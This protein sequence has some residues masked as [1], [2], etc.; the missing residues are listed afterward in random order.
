M[1]RTLFIILFLG[2]SLHSCRKDIS[3]DDLVQNTEGISV[4]NID[5][6]SVTGMQRIPGI[7]YTVIYSGSE[8]FTFSKVGS[9]LVDEYGH[10]ISSNLYGGSFNDNVFGFTTDSDGN[11][12]V[13][14]NTFSPELRLNIVP[15]PFNPTGDAYLCKLDKNGKLVWQIGYSDTTT[16]NFGSLAE[17]FSKV[18]VIGDSI[19]C[20]G[21]TE[22]YKNLG[23]PNPNDLLGDN[24]LVAFNKN[25]Q[26]GSQRILPNLQ[27]SRAF[28]PYGASNDMIKCANN[29]LI[30]INNV[31]RTFG[32]VPESYDTSCVIT[33]YSPS[34]RSVLWT[35]YGNR[36]ALEGDIN[37]MVELANGDLFCLNSFKTKSVRLSGSSG[38][39]LSSSDLN[40][41]EDIP[42]GSFVTGSLKIVG[43]HLYLVGSV[44]GNIG[45]SLGIGLTSGSNR[46]GSKPW[47]VK[48]DLEGNVIYAQLYDVEEAGF[49]DILQKED[50]NLQLLG[51]VSK[52]GTLSYSGFFLTLD[53]KGDIVTN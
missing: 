27:K 18:S 45:F 13:C 5:A 15:S 28:G 46:K 40:I 9:A 20:Y 47:L 50:G 23:Q 6:R 19:Y 35:A 22:N 3:E 25:G 42:T 8:N 24:W 44:A 11:T 34:T 21:F 53:S 48:M 30:F 36:D 31:D 14:G 37:Q 12:Y 1:I 33:R 41:L 38:D 29:D 43:E 26:F 16:G 39:V 51:G 2:V 10:L 4:F 17:G 32:P 49:S 7:G 52:Y